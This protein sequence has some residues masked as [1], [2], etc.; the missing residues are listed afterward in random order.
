MITPYRILVADHSRAM[1]RILRQIV[2]PLGFQIAEAEDG[3]EALQQ[4]IEHPEIELILFDGKLTGI[5][6][7]EFV[8]IVKS[9][10]R[11]QQIKLVLVTADTEPSQMARSLMSGIDAILVKPFT[12]DMF[13]EKLQLIDDSIPA[14]S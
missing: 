2:E 1:R 8:R 3:F 9:N 10:P 5:S 13:L 14:V 12:P 4:L 11:Q 7:S 6:A